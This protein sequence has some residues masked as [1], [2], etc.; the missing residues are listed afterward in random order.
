MDFERAK[1][2][3]GE[4]FFDRHPELPDWFDD[5]VTVSGFKNQNKQWVLRYSVSPSSP[6][7]ENQKWEE[8]RGNSVVVET[9]PITG[10]RSILLSREGPAPVIIFEATIDF[11]TAA[12]SV[13]RD[14]DLAALDGSAFENYGKGSSNWAR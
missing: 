1:A 2:L 4:V 7:K 9:N 5:C 12:V 11:S 13:V 8:I 3:V 14:G 6:L 10:E